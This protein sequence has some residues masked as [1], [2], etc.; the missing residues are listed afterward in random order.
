M[1]ANEVWKR[2]WNRFRKTNE[3]YF[4]IFPNLNWKFSE[5]AERQER[6]RIV[7]ILHVHR[8]SVRVV[9]CWIPFS[10]PSGP[11]VHRDRQTASGSEFNEPSDELLT[12]C[13]VVKAEVRVRW[14]GHHHKLI[15]RLLIF[16]RP[17][18]L[19]PLDIPFEVTH[20]FEESLTGIHSPQTDPPRA[21]RMT[22]VT[23]EFFSKS[24]GL[25]VVSQWT[26]VGD[27]QLCERCEKLV[28]LPI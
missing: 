24:S 26:E 3:D 15:F 7:R 21:D 20:V 28:T 11:S 27:N 2:T 4:D 23:S 14:K 25:L 6:L 9:T 17:L 13:L 5:S 18:L 1:C 8:I 16:L 19:L 12:A 22:N 10:D